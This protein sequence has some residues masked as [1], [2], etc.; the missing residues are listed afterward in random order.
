MMCIGRDYSENRVG[1]DPRQTFQNWNVLEIIAGND[2]DRDEDTGLMYFNARWYDADTG[3]FITEDPV[4]D[5]LLWYAYANNNPLKF[6]DPTGF[7]PR[8][9][10]AEQ[11]K[12]Y[13]KSIS[14]ATL[15]N[16]PS[17]L[18]YRNGTNGKIDADC[19]DIAVFLADNAMEKA[20]GKSDYYKGLKHM[21]NPIEDIVDI[22]SGDFRDGDNFTFYRD[23]DGNIENDFSF[24]GIEVGTIGVFDNHIVTVIGIEDDFIIT[25]EGHTEK[26]G[27]TSIDRIKNQSD[28]DSYKGTF[29]GWGE[30]GKDSA[31]LDKDH[32]DEDDDD[33]PK[34]PEDSQDDTDYDD[35]FDDK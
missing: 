15:A 34:I 4:K 26:V 25:M 27:P 5:G 8:N 35:P 33:E 18:P 6:T 13:K 29:L 16:T 20:T 28:L 31:D 7:A 32:D 10:T 30:I 19:A 14:S 2:I 9:L 17:E 22:S 1:E 11:R 23:S 12:E 21:S 24:E 3:R